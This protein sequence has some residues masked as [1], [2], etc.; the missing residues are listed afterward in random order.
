M[1]NERAVRYAEF[2]IFKDGAKDF[3]SALSSADAS[4]KRLD[5]F[6]TL[7]ICPGGRSGGLSKRIIEVYFGNRPYDS[8]TEIGPNAGL[9]N[10][11]E[12]AY[13]AMLAYFR[14]DEGHVVCH[15]YPAGT[16]NQKAIEDCIL[17]DQLADPRQL[18]KVARS[19][20]KSLVAYME[21]TSIDGSPSLLQT[22]RVAYL[23]NFKRCI[24]E[25]KVLDRKVATAAREV[26]KWVVTVGLSGSVLLLISQLQSKS[27]ELARNTER[28]ESI[29]IL[30]L[31]ATELQSISSQTWRIASELTQ[32]RHDLE[33][34]KEQL[35][36]SN[37]STEEIPTPK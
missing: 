10:R 19:H 16:D 21:A 33:K 24:V 34:V 25:S 27:D 15:L 3:F 23:R 28:E 36:P 6:F 32:I 8:V 5:D 11:L 2:E 37:G 9:I 31:S 7:N 12:F 35:D 29:K 30:Q 20:W 18:K 17:L 13:G 22:L 14:T 4:A 1:K 26:L